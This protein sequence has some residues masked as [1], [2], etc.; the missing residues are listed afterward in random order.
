MTSVNTLSVNIT[1]PITRTFGVSQP[2][3]TA[4]PNAKDLELTSSLQ[5]TLNQYNSYE[6]QEETSQRVKVLQKLN[7]CVKQWIQKITE[8]RY[9]KD[10][11]FNAGGQLMA[12]GSYRLGVHS[13]GAD[14]DTL[15]LA[16]RHATRADFFSSFKQM[17]AKD[18]EVT[19]L[20]AVENAFVPIMTMKYSGIEI[21]FLFARLALKEV[22]EDLD[23]LD[24]ALL[25]NLDQESV[26]SLN[27]CRVAENLLKLVPNQE[28]F[29]ITLRAIKLWAKNHGIYSNSMGFFGGITWAILVARACQLYPNASPSKLI[30]KVFFIFST[31]KWP[32]PVL[33]DFISSDRMDLAQLNQLVWD[34]RRN[35]SD[36]YHLMPI[37]TPAFP[38][39]NSTHNVS[40]SSMKVI[41]EEMKDALITCDNI[42]NGSCNWMDLLEE[43]N[44]F[45]RYKHFISLSMTAETEKDEL[46]FGGFF[47][48]RIRQLV[49]ILEKN[50]G[51]KLAHINPKK[52]KA[53]KDPKKSVWFIGLQF[54][55]NVKNLDLTK[56]I[57]QFKR[58]IDYQAK[59]VKDIEANCAVET[60]FSYVKRS[61]LAQTIS[62]KDLKQGKMYKKPE[63]KDPVSKKRK[64]S[65]NAPSVPKKQKL[66]VS[67]KSSVESLLKNLKKKSLIV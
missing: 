6:P 58:N 46:A 23:I 17:L 59:S 9:P 51:I 19:N 36:R 31:W 21:D 30:Q 53:A 3:S 56:D 26:R 38:Q 8:A 4:L 24:D 50:Q 34:P 39:Q 11:L 37:V 64:V 2:I 54:D 55:E 42:Q 45:S 28:N 20:C 18:P 49:L 25:K 62:V 35:Q 16:P 12:F 13:S 67:E 14:I 33:L 44:F 27:G 1:V 52:F 65:E 7:G 22:P 66:D 41:Q 29:C 40:R 63:S 61:D 60:D 10:Q 57:Q 47:E 32:A 43:I 5:K 15:V 48:S